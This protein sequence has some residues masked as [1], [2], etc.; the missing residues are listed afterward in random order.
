MM[1]GSKHVT[2]TNRITIYYDIISTAQLASYLAR[3]ISFFSHDQHEWND[4]RE[5]KIFIYIDTMFLFQF[6]I[7]RKLMTRR[8]QVNEHTLLRYV[9]SQLSC[10]QLVAKAS[11]RSFYRSRLMTAKV[12]R[13][14]E[15]SRDLVCSLQRDNY[16]EYT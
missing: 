15:R 11:T 6:E 1:A 13:Y 14:L 2:C 5:L 9:W 12:C 8:A 7:T 10:A 16:N 4:A 3:Y